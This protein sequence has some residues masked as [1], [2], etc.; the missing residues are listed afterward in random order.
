MKTIM[1]YNIF[2]HLKKF[3]APHDDGKTCTHCAHFVDME[4]NDDA[5]N[6]LCNHLMVLKEP[7]DLEYKNDKRTIVVRPSTCP[8]WTPDMYTRMSVFKYF[9][10]V[11]YVMS[12]NEPP[13][14]VDHK[15]NNLMRHF[16]G[17]WNIAIG[18][19]DQTFI[20][21]QKTHSRLW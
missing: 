19:A 6:L 2:K 21:S 18:A 20:H 16:Y 10:A 9:A 1:S 12:H 8:G 5:F 11:F 14:D 4:F 3:D 13:E 7:C 15:A 17:E